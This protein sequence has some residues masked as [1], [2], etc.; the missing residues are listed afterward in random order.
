MSSIFG[1]ID[2]LPEA[3]A[4]EPPPSR[5]TLPWREPERTERAPASIMGC[6]RPTPQPRRTMPMPGPK[7]GAF[8]MVEEV[9][10]TKRDPRVD[11]E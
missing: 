5:P 3:P 2:E 1:Q 4:E 9:V 8:A 6:R 11:E 10:L 7:S